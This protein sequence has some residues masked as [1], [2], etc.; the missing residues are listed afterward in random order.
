MLQWYQAGVLLV[1]GGND[2]GVVWVAWS[3]GVG[4]FSAK[5]LAIWLGLSL[6]HQCGFRISLINS[7][8]TVEIGWM[9]KLHINFGVQSFY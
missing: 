4:D 3:F 7:D 6:V 5:L 1:W 9:N 8:S 2:M